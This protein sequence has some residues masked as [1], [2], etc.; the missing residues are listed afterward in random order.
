MNRFT[1]GTLAAMT[2]MLL[3]TYAG[4]QT[5]SGADAMFE[6]ARQKETLEGDLPGAIKEYGAIVAKYKSDRGVT[7]MALVRMAECYQKM[8]DSE[9]RKIYE[10]V[11]REYAD[12]KDAVAIARTQLEAR[13]RPA[14]SPS[15]CCA[16]N[17]ATRMRILARTDA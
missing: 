9:S 17:A 15:V 6:A 11:L 3:M 13:V 1:A 7:A 8:G 14:P 5:R 12:Q 4:A 10:Q 16:P 2:A